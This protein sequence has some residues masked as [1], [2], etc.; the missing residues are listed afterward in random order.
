MVGLFLAGTAQS[1][2]SAGTGQVTGLFLQSERSD[3]IGQGYSHEFYDDD[4]SEFTIEGSPGHLWYRAAHDGELWDVDISPPAGQTLTAGQTYQA[5][6]DRFQQPGFA[7]LAVDGDGRGCDAVT[8]SVTVVQYS[9]V[10]S[11][12]TWFFNQLDVR[13]TQ[14]CD[15]AAGV[16]TGRAAFHAGPPPVSVDGT[17]TRATPYGSSVLL[18]G[19]APA[20]A[21]VGI[22]FH[23]AGSTGYVQRRSLRASPSGTW[24]TS[25]VANDDYRIYATSG[26]NQSSPVLVQVAPTITGPSSRVVRRNSTVTIAGTGSPGQLVTLHF[27]RAGTAATDYSILRAVPVDAAGRWSRSYVATTDYRYYATL[28]NGQRS[29]TVLTQA[30]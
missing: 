18:T 9:M 24:S 20:G 29:A 21:P 25:Y 16:L 11:G 4:G 13:F 27:H 7:G 19:K 28:P 5:Q 2:A 1:G 8:G 15:G 10:K 3:P 6:R 26:T 14:R 23:E 12:D 30:R 22:W 17:A